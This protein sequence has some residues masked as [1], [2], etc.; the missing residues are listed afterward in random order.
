[1]IILVEGLDGTGKTTLCGNLRKC[2]DQSVVWH[3]E[4]SPSSIKTVW[5]VRQWYEKECANAPTGDDATVILDRWWPTTLAFTNAY[6]PLPMKELAN[7]WASQTPT[8]NYIFQLVCDCEAAKKR[9]QERDG[10]LSPEES[11]LY[12]KGAFGNNIQD[13]LD[14][15][16]SVLRSKGAKVYK[17]LTEFSDTG[18]VFEAVKDTITTHFSHTR[19]ALVTEF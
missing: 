4:R 11:M 6:T 12:D 15:C 1:M 13:S 17:V 18:A 19:N 3:A 7:V 9:I 16:Y 8:P 2:Y 5:G 10:V 14:T